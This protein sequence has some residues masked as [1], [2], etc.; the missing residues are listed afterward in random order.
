V[1]SVTDPYMKLNTHAI[2]HTSSVI[3]RIP[4]SVNLNCTGTCL[5]FKF[6]SSFELLFT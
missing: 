5:I 3:N 1:V 2:I 4:S 6:V